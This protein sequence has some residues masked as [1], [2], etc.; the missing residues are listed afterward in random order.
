MQEVN[1]AINSSKAS[2]MT[3]KKGHNA[4]LA[5]IPNEPRT[6]TPADIVANSLFPD[7]GLNPPGQKINFSYQNKSF[8]K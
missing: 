3:Q 4:F 5:N 8:P 6:L 2:Q 7:E 1:L